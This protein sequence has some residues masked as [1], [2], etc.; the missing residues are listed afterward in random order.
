MIYSEISTGFQHP[1][2]VTI[3]LCRLN[4]VRTVVLFKTHSSIIVNL[5]RHFFSRSLKQLR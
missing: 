5:I 2:R 1:A 4:K 3:R